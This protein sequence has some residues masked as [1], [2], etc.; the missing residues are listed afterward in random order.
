M[1]EHLFE[2]FEN[3]GAVNFL[4][5]LLRFRIFLIIGKEASPPT[6]PLHWENYTFIS[7]HIEWD[8]IMVTVFLSILNQM[9][10]HLVQY[11]KENCHYNHIPLYVKGNESIVFSVHGFYPSR[12]Q[13]SSIHLERRLMWDLPLLTHR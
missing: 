7:F 8:M 9:E 10:F 6:Y 2:L 1:S 5:R 13:G 11:Q 12:G 4:K 3:C